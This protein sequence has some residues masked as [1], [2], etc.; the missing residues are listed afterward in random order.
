MFSLKNRKL[1]STY[2]PF[3]ITIIS[4]N[5]IAVGINFRR[6]P[7]S[8]TGIIQVTTCWTR[9]C[10]SIVCEWKNTFTCIFTLSSYTLWNTKVNYQVRIILFFTSCDENLE[11]FLSSSGHYYAKIISVCCSNPK[12]TNTCCH[13]INLDNLGMKSWIDHERC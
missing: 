4:I 13:R 2:C 8:F 5:M 1:T 3:T 7:S 9:T 11:C 12:C 10:F 6:T